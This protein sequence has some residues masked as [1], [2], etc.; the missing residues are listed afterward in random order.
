MMNLQA[1][2]HPGPELSFDEVLYYTY[3]EGDD[4]REGQRSQADKVGHGGR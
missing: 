1:T 2:P 3:V 4:H